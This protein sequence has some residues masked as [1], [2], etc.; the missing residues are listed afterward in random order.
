MT[1]GDGLSPG[2]KPRHTWQPGLRVE[3][4]PRQRR[5]YDMPPGRPSRAARV[6][7]TACRSTP[8]SPLR[9]QAA[10]PTSLRAR[11]GGAPHQRLRSAPRRG[12]HG[13]VAPRARQALV[14]PTPTPTPT[15]GPVAEA[16]AAAVS[17]FGGLARAVASLVQVECDAGGTAGG[18]VSGA[19]SG[20]VVGAVSGYHTLG[21]QMSA[22]ETPKAHDLRRPRRSGS[23]APAAPPLMPLHSMARASGPV[24]KVH[25]DHSGRR[26]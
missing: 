4:P 17:F 9:G 2:G 24:G 22:L 10:A 1:Y 23:A 21:V 14:T 13:D 6:G 25:N 26:A 3:T 19:V 15:P 12:H 16:I 8:R 20:A 5:A 7:L 18:A 11:P